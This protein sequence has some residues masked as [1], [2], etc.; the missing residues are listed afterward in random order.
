MT[1]RELLRAVRQ[2]AWLLFLAGKGE[3]TFE[4]AER[5]A[6]KEIVAEH[7]AQ[8][9]RPTAQHAATANSD[10]TVQNARSVLLAQLRTLGDRLRNPLAPSAPP[11]ASG[12]FEATSKLP[13]AVK[14]TKQQPEPEPTPTPPAANPVFVGN[15]S[16]AVLIPDAEFEPRWRAQSFATDNWHESIRRNEIIN[17]QNGRWVG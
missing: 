5:Q 16:S 12:S 13:P 2:R 10:I 15:S 11:V 1:P 7:K 8:P 3:V 14:T 6:A 9:R 4:S 17:R